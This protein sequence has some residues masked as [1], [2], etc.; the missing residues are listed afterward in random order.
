MSKIDKLKLSLKEIEDL[1]INKKELLEDMSSESIIK[2]YD[3][4]FK[5]KYKFER[6]QEKDFHK[7]VMKSYKNMKQKGKRV[8][9]YCNESGKS[10]VSV[11]ECAKWLEKETGKNINTIKSRLYI[12]IND[13]SG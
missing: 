2:L 3:R 7:F 13:S 5:L 9:I 4:Y 1:F 6:A 8:I 12:Y 10:F 11:N